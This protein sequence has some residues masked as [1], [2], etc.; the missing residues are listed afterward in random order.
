MNWRTAS[1]IDVRQRDW[2]KMLFILIF[3]CLIAQVWTLLTYKIRGDVNVINDEE[4][5]RKTFLYRC[6]AS[7]TVWFNFAHPDRSQVGKGAVT[8][9]TPLSGKNSHCPVWKHLYSCWHPNPAESDH[10]DHNEPLKCATETRV[11]PTC[12][13]WHWG[14]I[15]PRCLF[16]K[17]EKYR[18]L[19]GQRARVNGRD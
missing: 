17:M 6:L 4:G 10:R 13:S 5:L 8:N 18:S 15:K 16:M 9:P 7:D 1:N 14:C 19:R 11:R 12:V 3:H 2:E